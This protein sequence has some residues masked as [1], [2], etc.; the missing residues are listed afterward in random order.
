MCLPRRISR[1]VVMQRWAYE[2]VSQST[3]ARELGCTRQAVTKIVDQQGMAGDKRARLG[4]LRRP[5][6]ANWKTYYPMMETGKRRT[7]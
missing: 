7:Q 3:I 1:D 4:W 5:R 2:T 6:H